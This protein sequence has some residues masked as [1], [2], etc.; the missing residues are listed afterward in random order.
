LF[1]PRIALGQLT[2]WKITAAKSESITTELKNQRMQKSKLSLGL[3]MLAIVMV[4]G[5]SFATPVGN[6]PDAGSSALL[7]SIAFAGL[8]AVRKLMR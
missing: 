5:T 4:T 1:G 7:M 6:A 2:L 3:V 8:A